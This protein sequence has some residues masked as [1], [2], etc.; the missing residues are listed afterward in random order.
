M[1][2]GGGRPWY[3]YV[4]TLAVIA[5]LV[6]YIHENI[7]E[8]RRYQFHFQWTLMIAGF[9]SSIAGL[10]MMFLAWERLSRCFGL[11]APRSR[12]ARAFFTSQLGKY[13]PGKVGLVLVRMDSYRGYS[14]RTVALA[15]GIEY[16]L[17]FVSACILVLVSTLFVRS[18]L[19]GMVKWLAAGM[20]AV[21][22]VALWPPFLK[23]AA[24]RVF[25]LLRRQPV[26][27]VP[28]YGSILVLVLMYIAAGLLFGLGLFTVLN[29]LSGLSLEYYLPVTGTFWAAT[30]VG[31]AAVFAPSGI[32]VREGVLMLVL[33]SFVPE[34]T[35]IVG[36][37]LIRLVMMGAELSLAGLS[38]VM[39]R[40]SAQGSTAA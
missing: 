17:S 4:L 14:R 10:M 35:V 40:S 15:T 39:D 5:A 20:L 36:A 30:L 32:G 18:G 38:R 31:I 22:L 11:T 24:D 28:S 8:I 27:N 3:S 26:E 7:G 21:M 1:R 13:V 37:I 34:P 6:Y 33:P 16:V 12:A 19:P 23:A 29:S 9:L 25:R 2:Q